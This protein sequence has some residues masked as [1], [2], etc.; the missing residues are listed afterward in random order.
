MKIPVPNLVAA[1][2]LVRNL[3]ARTVPLY[4]CT[5]ARM[6]EPTRSLRSGTKRAG[7]QL[8]DTD[9]PQSSTSTKN[10]KAKKS[11][12]TPKVSAPV[13]SEPD[14]AQPWYRFFTKGDEMYE[15]YMADEWGFEKHGDEALFE[16]LSLEG[17]QSGLSWLTILRKRQAYRDAFHNFDPVK[18]AAMTPVDVDRILS[19]SPGDSRQVV[20][21]HRGKL[22]SVINNA[23]CILEM[24]AADTGAASD[25][26]VFDHFM[27]SFVNHQ[28]I[29]NSVTR[30]TLPTKSDE[31]EAM[32][33]ALKKRGFKFV[34]PTTCY[35]LMQAT[36]M[37]LDHL[38]D[39]PEW[40]RVRN[41]LRERTG[42]YQD[43]TTLGEDNDDNNDAS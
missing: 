9:N 24:R 1:S 16:K 20:V 22:E 36:G 6:S 21:R 25:F 40:H 5:T 43:R 11:T 14:G 27:W 13:E 28:P 18:V 31:S 3:V 41:R 15:R 35:A 34:G 37:V 8:T 29:L 30:S 33:K 17:A 32:S 26:G 10:S 7:S 39:S 12:R 42:G 2:S 4:T 23:K 19:E 38:Y